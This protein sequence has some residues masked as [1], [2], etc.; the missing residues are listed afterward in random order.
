MLASNCCPTSAW[1]ESQ[2][3][4]WVMVSQGRFRETLTPEWHWE[5]ATCA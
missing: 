4:F 3:T 2:S 1:Q 5:Q